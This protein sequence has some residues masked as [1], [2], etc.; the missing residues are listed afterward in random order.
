M[1]WIKRLLGDKL[2]KNIII[3]STGTGIAQIFPFLVSIFISRV[4]SP[5]ELGTYAL[6]YSLSAIFGTLITLGYENL[7]Y[8]GKTKIAITHGIILCVIITVLM[9]SFLS[10]AMFFAPNSLFLWFGLGKIRTFLPFFFLSFILSTLSTLFNIRFVKEGEFRFLSKAKIYFSMA[11]AAI[12]VIFGLMKIGAFGLILANLVAY[13]LADIVYIF[14]LLNKNILSLNGIRIKYLKLLFAKYIN[15]SL[16]MTP[17]SVISTISNEIPI[18]LLSRLFGEAI[19]GFYSFGQKVIV[20]PLSFIIS[21]VQDVFIKEASDE[22]IRERNCVNIYKKTLKILIPLLLVALLGFIFLTPFVF[23]FLFGTKWIISAKIVQITCIFFIV[24]SLSS[25]LSYPIILAKKQKINL[26]F[27]VIL[28]ITT[29]LSFY[30][31]FYLFKDVIKVLLLSS[32][33]NVL[34][35]LYYMK[36]SYKA[37]KNIQT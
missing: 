17:S 28:L 5:T 19:V 13:A 34:C 18:F 21:S 12:Q 37:A 8:L 16:Y 7:I 9:S 22:F 25:I 14:F 20:L 35:Y 2:L 24:R 6:F 27:L 11:S 26:F 4:Y 1:N 23:N 32:F 29:V 3:L 31:G 36:M 10:I 30:I 33:I 15:F